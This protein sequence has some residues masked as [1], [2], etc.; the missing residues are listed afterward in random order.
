MPFFFNG[1]VVAVVC[2]TF[3]T[4]E[5]FGSEGT[6][7]FSWGKGPEEVRLTS[8]GQR[9]SLSSSRVD[10]LCGPDATHLSFAPL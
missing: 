8:T 7:L 5:D 6:S 10:S 4:H 9:R 3:I 2:T 1:I